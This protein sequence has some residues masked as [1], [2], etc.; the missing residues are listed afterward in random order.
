[1]N[2]SDHFPLSTPENDMPPIPPLSSRGPLVCATIQ[3][4]LAILQDLP[5][6]QARPVLEHART[7]SQCEPVLRLMRQTTMLLA[8]LPA[9]QPSKHVDRLVG[10]AIAGRE[11]RGGAR[12]PASLKRAA[13]QKETT[14]P[15]W[16]RR[17][18][19]AGALALVAVLL[20]AILATLQTL[21]LGGGPATYTTFALPASLSWNDYVLFHSQTRSDASGERYQV[22]TYHDI[23]T[24]RMHVETI[25]PG[26]MD[27]VAVGDEHAMLGLDMMHHVA[28]WGADSWSV[29]DSAFDLAG[30]RGDLKSGSAVYLGKDTFH[31]QPVYH[32]RY[33]TGQVLLLDMQY[34]PVNVLSGGTG[35]GSGRAM[36]DR[37]ELMPDSHVA[38]SM[39]DMSIPRDFH[40]GSLPNRP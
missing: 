8:G 37:V 14:R 39:W 32:I 30:L 6:E 12:A 2:T 31:G 22:E 15:A 10:Q 25:M 4:Y 40:M 13:L 1:M 27:V 9:S 35:P 11:Q 33:R 24:G 7:C 19:L 16:R 28:Q 23:S 3:L 36:Y 5:P 29:D 18:S 21:H 26:S 17:R 34:R 20:L 38:S